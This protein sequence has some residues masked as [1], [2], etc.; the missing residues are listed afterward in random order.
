MRL[1]QA[2]DYQNVLLTPNKYNYSASVIKLK[3]S[4]LDNELFEFKYPYTDNELQSVTVHL[5]AERDYLIR[6][7][8]SRNEKL[9]PQEMYLLSALYLMQNEEK[10][11]RLGLVVETYWALSNQ[12]LLYKEKN[13]NQFIYCDV[14]DSNILNLLAQET[15]IN[16]SV[17]FGVTNSFME[18]VNQCGMWDFTYK[19]KSISAVRLMKLIIDYQLKHDDTALF[20]IDSALENGLIKEDLISLN[21][22]QISLQ[23]NEVDISLL[24]RVSTILMRILANIERLD[25]TLL[26]EKAVSFKIIGWDKLTKQQ[27][28]MQTKK[29]KAY[30]TELIRKMTYYLYLSSTQITKENK[31]ED[32][33]DL[34]YKQQLI[35]ISNE[36][37]QENLK[38]LA[39]RVEKYGLNVKKVLSCSVHDLVEINDLVEQIRY[40]NRIIQINLPSGA[41]PYGSYLLE[42]HTKNWR[43]GIY[44]SKVHK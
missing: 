28:W 40:N 16:N 15:I 29:G 20:F 33:Y 38:L 6:D 34:K 24:R 14:A 37:G 17:V 21:N 26:K 23:I 36:C 12:Y 27:K 11:K 10:S 8:Q 25:T 31:Q 39:P 32:Q 41:L 18:K 2:L 7:K 1:L 44:L 19:N 9:L 4:I 22:P 43:E 35:N 42:Q 30:R 3:R 13:N 5:A